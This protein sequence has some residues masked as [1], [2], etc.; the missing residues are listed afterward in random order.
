MILVDNL[1]FI[2]FRIVPILP[3][4]HSLL[5]LFVVFFLT[6]SIILYLLFSIL[7][8][9][10]KITEGIQ[11]ESVITHQEIPFS[12]IF[13]IFFSENITNNC[14]KAKYLYVRHFIEQQ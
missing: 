7:Y 4:D 1:N 10:Q 9:A 13:N 8:C 6:P 14:L 2:L 11:N 5:L 3:M 12:V